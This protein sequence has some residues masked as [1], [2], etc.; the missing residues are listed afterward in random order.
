MGVWIGAV[1]GNVSDVCGCHRCKDFRMHAGPVVTREGASRMLLVGHTPTITSRSL[2][3]QGDRQTAWW[4]RGLV[5]V[6]TGVNDLFHL[7]L[8][9]LLPDDISNATVSLEPS[10][11]HHERRELHNLRV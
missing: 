10:L 8:A 3:G 9:E 2:H 1:R 5:K 7:E 11:H 6:A 4:H